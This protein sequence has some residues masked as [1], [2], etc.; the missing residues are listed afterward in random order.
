[1]PLLNGGS[2]RS[3]G[4]MLA[5]GHGDLVFTAHTAPDGV[6]RSWVVVVAGQTVFP[7]FVN[8]VHDGFNSLV[9]VLLL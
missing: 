6:T 4:Y 2:K 7:V 8:G 3:L 1:L 5:V 9:H